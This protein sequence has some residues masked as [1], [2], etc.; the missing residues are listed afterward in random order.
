MCSYRFIQVLE[1]CV[2]LNYNRCGELISSLEFSIQFDERFK[3]ISERF[4]I[5]DYNLL[6]FELDDLIFKVLN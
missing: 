5:G 2:S 3:V 6:S 4:F 1:A